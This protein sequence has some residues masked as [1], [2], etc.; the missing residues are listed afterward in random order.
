MPWPLRDRHWL[1]RTS[2][3]RKLAEATGNEIWE[4][5]WGLADDSYARIA[6]IARRNVVDNLSREDFRRAVILPRNNG[7]W[8][9]TKVSE[10]QTLVVL[11]ATMDMGGMVPD[12]LVAR[13]TRKQLRKM[14]TKIEA[15][16]DTAYA[17][18]DRRYA[19]YRGDGSLIESRQQGE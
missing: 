8:V 12:G 11:H 7:A 2:K 15:D 3:N 10:N 9:M 17:N 13:S 4:H 6:D 5:H 1:I 19:I 18:Y 16:S 14:L